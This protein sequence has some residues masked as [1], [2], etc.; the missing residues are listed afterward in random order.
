MGGVNFTRSRAWWHTVIWDEYGQRHQYL[1]MFPTFAFMIPLYWYGSFINRNLEQDYAA[2]MY[3]LDYENK[4]NRLTHNLIME[5]FETHV[6]KVQDI[7]DEVKK[8]GF[9]KAF[10]YEIKHPF[11]EYIHEPI[12]SLNEEFI[13]EI[14]EYSG[15]TQALD[16]YLEHHDLP[17]WKRQEIE[18][19]MYRRK[20]PFAPYEYINR[21]KSMKPM[22]NIAHTYLDPYQVQIMTP[23]QGNAQIKDEGE[24]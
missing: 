5:H 19:Y 1:C 11:T 3:Q 18:K 14:A 2:K 17:Y 13:A 6:E 12:P 8:E 24:S 21:T 23:T 22:D 4:R 7:L 10:E 16:E 9:E 20:T 15:L